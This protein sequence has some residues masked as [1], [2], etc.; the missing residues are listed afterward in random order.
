NITTSTLSSNKANTSGGAIYNSQS[1]APII[2]DCIFA[3]N[4][5]LNSGG[6]IYNNQS[7]PKIANSIF[8]A[9]TANRAG[10][11]FNSDSG[12]KIY[13]TL[14]VKNNALTAGAGAIY[15]NNNGPGNGFTLANCILYGNTGGTTSWAGGIHSTSGC[16]IYNS[17]IWGN[18]GG[19]LTGGFIIKNSLV[20]GVSSTAD[21]NLDAT[22]INVAQLFNN[23]NGADGILGTADD[24]FNLIAGSP[25]IEK[26]DNILYT[27]TGGNLSTDK[28]LAGNARFQGTKID[29]GAFEMT[30]ISQTITATDMVKTY[31]DIPFVPTAT[32]S[33]GLEVNYVS[34]DNSIAEAFQDTADGNKW[35]LKIKKAGTV[36]ITAKQAGN[37]TYNPATDVIFKL[38]I[39]KAPLTVTAHAKSKESGAADPVLTYT[40]NGLVNGDTQTVIFGT[41]KRAI[42][43]AVGTYPI[44]QG[45][46]AA[47]NYTIS[48]TGA[49]FT[50]T[51]APGDF[52]TVWDMTKVTT[53][54]IISSV[55]ITTLPSPNNQVKYFWTAPDGSTG[56]GTVTTSGS[57]RITIPAN[58]PTITLH[59]KPEN[60]ASVIILNEPRIIDVAQ[61]GTAEW[62][63][64]QNAFLQCSNLNVT[65][66]DMPNLS[67]VTSMNGM[68]ADCSSLTGPANIGSWNTSN[69][70]NMI[71]LF[72]RATRFN[73]DI[74][75][76]DTQNVT[77]MAYMFREA[78]AFNQNIGNWNTSKVTD[79]EAMFENASVFNQD[80]SNW[81]TANVTNM[82]KIFS[83]A[84]VFNQ[85]IGSWNTSNV[86]NMSYMFQYTGAFNGD[87]SSWNTAN[88]TNMWGM[89]Y[90]TVAF[91]QNIGNWDT[92]NVT[93]MGG[94][95][96]NARAFNQDIS[97]WNT[98]KVTRMSFMFADNRAFNKDIGNWDTANVTDMAYM[99]RANQAFNKDIGNWNTANVTDMS[100][101]FYDAQTFN[102]NI[103]SWQLNPAVNMTNMLSYSSLDCT[104]YSLT[105]NGWA[106]NPN[107]PSG[108]NLRA[109]DR[110]YGTNA[111]TARTALT[112]TKGWTITGDSPSGQRCALSQT[113]TTTDMVKT[114]GDVAFVPTAT[115]SSNLEVSYTS[116]D[117]S[118]AE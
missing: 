28:D 69:V 8:R 75:N 12:P 4:T 77:T 43:E 100:Y 52:I 25:L 38:T 14:F 18:Q 31:G 87:I 65:A 15:H 85:N 66:T 63:T 78:R 37:A 23:P 36:T 64:M 30:L 88:V 83:S 96:W 33:S 34:A 98:S 95:F 92:S 47:A 9:N 86:T 40:T 24:N 89:F 111:H 118:I 90:S 2:T 93:Y 68:F 106:N 73:Q 104:N 107:T 84:L 49:D 103:G 94:M 116:A 110:Q 56:S 80:I 50:I 29:I 91:N 21:G 7:H 1:S 70:T 5:A 62:R 79:M 99:F 53:H 97:S 44:T 19:Q 27:N 26:G 67:R 55:K 13:N 82:S 57:L 109:L 58:K 54:T 117:N 39:E 61:W 115:A 20:Q 72:S 60:L 112:T 11:L 16:N 48:Y 59:I 74:S 6:A 71:T 102:Q 22:N 46:L 76:W 42:G 10:A 113:I 101:M 17:V 81:N 45:N 32:A 51:N 41:L 105:L 114:Y 35:K 3:A 108:R